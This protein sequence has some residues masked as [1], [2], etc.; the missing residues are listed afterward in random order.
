[1]LYETLAP[2]LHFTSSTNYTLVAQSINMPPKSRIPQT[3]SNVLQAHLPDLSVGKYHTTSPAFHKIQFVGTLVQWTT[4]ETDVINAIR[5][6]QTQLERRIISHETRFNVSEYYLSKEHIQVGDEH[7][8]QGRYQQ[9]LG[10]VVTAALRVGGVVEKFADYKASSS[11]G[12][13]LVPDIAII[14]TITYDLHVVGEVKVPWVTEHDLSNIAPG[15]LEFK[16]VLGK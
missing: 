14:G 9:N 12:S 5:P 7:G 2:N 16:T 6:F 1:M 13:K 11:T 3:A 4:F 15:S 10:Q 8:V